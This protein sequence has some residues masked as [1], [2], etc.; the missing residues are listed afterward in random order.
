MLDRSDKKTKSK[1]EKRDKFV[2]LAE[3][4][5]INAIKAIRVI[6]KLGNKSAYEYTEA[7]VKKIA[8][9]LTREVEA[10]KARMMQSGTKDSVEFTL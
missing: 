1:A 10:L 2:E 3:S 9:A 5:T 8:A 4:R 6:A 7:D